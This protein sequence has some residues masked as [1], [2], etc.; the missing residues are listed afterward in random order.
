MTAAVL[1][2]LA[3]ICL[4]IAG[5]VAVTARLSRAEARGKHH[6]SREHRAGFADPGDTADP[7]GGGWLDR[8]RP[9]HLPRAGC[10][11]TSE[12]LEDPWNIAA[13]VRPPDPRP[14]GRLARGWSGTEVMPAADTGEMLAH[15][16]VSPAELADRLDREHF[17]GEL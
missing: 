9:P 4:A 10:L 7:D 12:L 14:L 11:I 2:C 13:Q 5:L 16:H 1:I 3:V 8:I 6:L 15:G 17:R